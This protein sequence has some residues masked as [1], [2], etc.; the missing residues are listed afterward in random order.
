MKGLEYLE[1]NTS[2]TIKT[3]IIWLHGLGADGHDFEPIAT[4]L[5]LPAELGV[6]FIFPHAPLRHVSINQGMLMRAWYD[7]AHPNL[8]IEQDKAGIYES[9]ALVEQLVQTEIDAKRKI[10]L[11]GFSQGGAIAL[12]LGLRL[13]DT[14]QGILAMSTYL[15]LPESVIRERHQA[16]K[17]TPI[18]LMHGID[19]PVVPLELAKKSKALLEKLDYAIEWKTYPMPH[20]VHPQQVSDIRQWL[21]EKLAN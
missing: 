14:L 2:S 5:N 21:L 3:T 20:S 16:N 18:M 10:I 11:A 15:A 9:A 17:N 13:S 6:R 19:D 7:I 1:I 4:Q 12:H 8:D